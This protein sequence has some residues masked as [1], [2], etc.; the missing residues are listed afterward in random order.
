MRSGLVHDF[1]RKRLVFKEIF[2]YL[3]PPMLRL[4]LIFAQATTVAVATLFVVSTFRP[5]WLPLRPGVSAPI[6]QASGAAASAM[7]ANTYADAVQRAPP[8]VVNIFSSK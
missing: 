2:V 8:S 5:E 1:A 3:A 4:W 7:G 6:V